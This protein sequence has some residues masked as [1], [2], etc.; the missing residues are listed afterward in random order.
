VK[1]SNLVLA[2]IAFCLSLVA[3][4]GAGANR[5]LPGGVEE[6]ARVASAS[7]VIRVPKRAK[8][9]GHYVSP[10]TLSLS[11]ALAPAAGCTGCSAPLAQ[12]ANLRPGS[13]GCVDAASGTTCTLS[14]VLKPGSYTGTIATYDGPLNGS[15]KPTGTVLSKDQSFPMTVANGKANVPTITLSGVPSGVALFSLSPI[16]RVVNDSPFFIPPGGTTPLPAVLVAE[17]GTSARLAAYATDPDGNVILGP[18]APTFAV[19]VGGSFS[20]TTSGNIVRLTVPPLAN[21]NT[22]SMTIVASSPACVSTAAC[23]WN[24]YAGFDTLL[25]VADTGN[26]DVVLQTADSNPS[27][28]VVAT[29]TNGVSQPKDV[30]FDASGNLFVANFG[31][32]TVTEYAPPYTGAPKATISNAVFNPTQLALGSNG[33]LAVV[34]A[35][36]GTASVY[37]PP[38]SSLPAVI[39]VASNA[40]AFDPSGNLWIA[41]TL[42]AIKRYPP[43]FTTSNITTSVGVSTPL[44]IAFDSTGALYLVNH[45]NNLVEKF[46]SGSYAASVATATLTGATS[47]AVTTSFVV[48]CGNGSAGLY[49]TSLGTAALVDG[50]GATPCQPAFDRLYGIWLTD[51]DDGL[52]VGYP[53]PPGLG[54][55]VIQRAGLETPVAIA[56]FPGPPPL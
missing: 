11:L 30:K 2:P 25:A 10:S 21:S 22:V 52:L 15:N 54:G 40:V 13:P 5:S 20:A 28:P 23:T 27:D 29:I 48:V 50:A 24:M 55:E 3:C 26:N 18:G 4:S 46:N 43:P 42:N 47:I 14:L 6:P 31:N 38:Y 41:A 7:I 33:T 51:P 37:A 36:N 12:T 53:Y 8:H 56:S 49:G 39:S 19:S 16:A 35:G 34:N 9:R 44:A 32:G 45:G 1:R 17:E